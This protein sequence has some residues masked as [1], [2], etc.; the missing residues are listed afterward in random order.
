MNRS[1]AEWQ[2]DCI[3][4]KYWCDKMRAI[5]AKESPPKA[6]PRQLSFRFNRRLP[7]QIK[8]PS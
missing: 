1:R 4:A 8:E 2:R 7:P 6:E 5:L 3:V